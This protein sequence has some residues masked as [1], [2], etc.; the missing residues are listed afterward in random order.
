M[1][2]RRCLTY[3]SIWCLTLGMVSVAS[4]ED[5]P[6]WRCTPGRT[7]S[8]PE[9]LPR[10]MT[11]QWS[12][13]LPQPE[14]CWPSPQQHKLEFD[15]SYE[16]VAAGGLLF[17]PSMIRDCMTAYDAATGKQRWRFFA[18]GPVRFA[19]AVADGRLFFVSDDGYLYCLN[20]QTGALQWK[21]RGG[22]SERRLLGNGRLI[23]M[24]PARGA[25]VVADDT[26]Y[27]AAGIWPFMGIFIYAVSAESGEV[28]WQNSGSGSDFILQPHSSPAFAGVA[29]QGHLALA[30][31][32]L[33][34]PGGRSVP[35]ILNRKTG[36][37]LYYKIND[38]NGGYAV[39][40]AGERFLVDNNMYNLA[41]GGR[42]GKV[43]TGIVA[44]GA[45]VG[46]DAQG[47]IRA[48]GF[49]VNWTEYK[50]A[51]GRK[52]RRA[53][54]KTHWT[55]PAP[56]G[57]EKLL[58][59]TG[60]QF[61]VGGPGM[62]ATMA[63]PGAVK[64]NALIPQNS[65]WSYL[66]GQHPQG[67]WTN[68]KFDDSAWKKGKSGFGY[69]DDDDTTVLKDMQLN[70]TVVYIRKEF[71]VDTI[72]ALAE[73]QLKIRYDD[74]FIAYLNGKEV[75]R[76]GVG[77][78]SGANARGLKGH[79]AR[80]Y[81]IFQLGKIGKLLQPG[82]NV[83]AIE[84]HNG[85]AGSSDFS[86]DPF[87]EI[88]SDKKA[89]T[90]KA[91]IAGTP[92]TAISADGRL[93]VVTREGRISCFGSARGTARVIDE[94]SPVASTAQDE[95]ETRTKRL[96]KASGD[97]S[98]YCLVLG[99]GTGRLAEELVRQSSLNVIVLESDASKISP[100]R[101][102]W[103]STGIYGK[104]LAIVTGDIVSARLPKYLASLITS[105]QSAS[106]VLPAAESLARLFDCLRPYGGTACFVTAGE[107]SGQTDLL[108]KRAKSAIGV[109]CSTARAL[110]FALIQRPGSIPG[111]APWT[112]QYGDVAN[113]VC[114]RDRGPRPPLG[115]LWFG[116]TSHTDVL[117]R[118]G[119][120]PPEL[121]AGGRLFIQGIGVL[122]AR[123]V[124]TGRPLW[125]REFSSLNTFDM[126]Y[127]ATYNPDPHD[128]SYN[129]RHIP[130][131][132]AYGSNFVVTTDRVYLVTGAVCLVL[133]PATGETLGQWRLP[134]LGD[135]QEPNWGYIGVYEDLL[136]AGG[137]PYHIAEDKDKVVTADNNRYGAGSRFIV[138]LDRHTG[139]ELWRRA[140]TRNFRHNAIVVGKDR[141]YCIDGLSPKRL[142]LLARR[143][144]A[145]KSP[146]AVF[147]L[148]V[149]TGRELW[150]AEDKI[151]GTW[152][153]YS[154]EFDVLLVA[155]AR[156][157]D[158]ARDETGRGMAGYRGATGEA[159]WR[160]DEGY[161]GPCILHHDKIITQTGGGNVKSKLAATFDL[162]TG[163]R[164][165]YRHPLTG[166]NI[167]MG[168]VR[169]K[170][171]NTAVA[172]ENLLTFRSASGCYVDL[173]SDM[174]TVSIG[175]FKS[176]CTSNMIVADG[177]LNVPD[178]TRTCTCSY[179]NQTSL[180][181]IHM[182][183]DDVR[184][185]G[186]ESWSFD[187]LPAP[188]YP[189]EVQRVGIN[190]AAPGNRRDAKGTLWL[191]VPSAGGPS[192]DLPVSIAAD[193]PKLLRLH[194][195][196]LESSSS[197][198][199]TGPRWIAASGLEG[200]TRLS[201]QLVMKPRDP[202]AGATV[203]A[204][205]NNALAPTLPT[206]ALA[207]PERQSPP[208]PY[209]IRLHF[210]ELAGA[211]PGERVFDVRIQG[212]KVLSGFDIAKATGGV[213]KS[214]TAEFKGIE[215]SDQLRIDLSRSI[216]G[217]G[218]PPLLCGVE[219]LAEYIALE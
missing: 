5:W 135:V 10:E 94:A 179:Q 3:L 102:K 93:F 180:A 89:L 199:A 111:S 140:A 167:P 46:M 92:W 120:G 84:G 63:R 72:D 202:K 34:V 76:V 194:M 155:S 47:V 65:A 78:G 69:G 156:A 108:F 16:P 213:R 104:R 190:L 138:V 173:S 85:A 158:R 204:F 216:A 113:T 154:E 148:D 25:P 195:S 209:T 51:K 149:R 96:L 82:R 193:K 83:L 215:V 210:A 103:I 39:A 43:P 151:S 22:P 67:S 30:D 201:L 176:G 182:P 163:K 145:P 159:L 189:A 214:V 219:I 137:A 66:A 54:L 121:I 27:F 118:H 58:I 178:Y 28:I 8:S 90:W 162:L 150:R 48:H 192:P 134:A 53:N 52:R 11:L 99:A 87:L 161:A 80:E 106:A 170:G 183:D 160:N 32:L 197:D 14:S 144:S 152:L 126:Y 23:S 91:K 200:I 55:Q 105:E 147:A 191:E 203:S 60:G 130:G 62:V 77:E 133:D 12:L 70:Y 31:E 184:S 33:I 50:D 38:K 68:T 171:C 123:D 73:L 115:L 187:H 177:V 122:S 41:D 18:N 19:P 196:Q 168:W 6:M 207:P 217:R 88:G 206:A 42:I 9:E 57:V 131:A 136:I 198:Q 142:A 40:V 24:W 81:E 164:S 4:A 74:A 129:Q 101:Q 37:L 86:L 172:S 36:K 29:P 49:G 169:F 100:L 127:N 2:F 61:V 188:E 132:N 205:A 35:A 116:G 110:G 128:R 7:A 125:R 97:P 212:K 181:L 208:R 20:A 64:S 114:S 44:D 175:G 124:Y 117:P 146:A 157:G 21:L 165:V 119:H 174:G 71:A 139:K 1:P 153:G 79:E 166:Q 17:V 26:V 109:E 75:L 15:L 45:V 141:L 143:G 59:S 98:G 95:W 211:A 112:H 13:Q 218:R 186:I 107:A 56:E 185:P